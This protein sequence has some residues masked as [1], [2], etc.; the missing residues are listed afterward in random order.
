MAHHEIGSEFWD[1]PL[2]DTTFDGI[3]DDAEWYVSGRSALCRVIRDITESHESFCKIALPSWCCDSMIIP[4]VTNGI[5]VDFYSVYVDNDQVLV[6]D[7]SNAE[8]CD[9]ILIMD[10]FGYT[11]ESAA[12]GFSGIVIRD[13]TH[14]IFSTQYDDYDYAFASLRKWAGFWTGGVS[15]SRTG[16]LTKAGRVAQQDQYVS[17]RKAAMA[18]KAEYIRGVRKDKGYLQEFADAEELLDGFGI[19]KAAERDIKNAKHID[20][21]LL[22]AKRRANAQALLQAVAGIAMFPSIKLN[23]CPLFVPILVKDGRRESLRR[24]FIENDVY[25]PVHW[26]ESKYHVLNKQTRQI[27]DN[28]LSLVCDQRYELADM[29]R[30]CSLIESYFSNKKILRC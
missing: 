21:E 2:C 19:S 20:V 24:F 11:M 9:A 30:V 4:F 18:G 22:R 15:W 10:Y 27:Y 23:E 14:S 29:E 28:E 12:I 8:G 16:W 7:F 1:I 3:P 13:V 5:E 26:R 17:L 6:R 25:C